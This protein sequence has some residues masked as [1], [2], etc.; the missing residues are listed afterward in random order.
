MVFGRTGK[1]AR[2]VF[3][4]GPGAPVSGFSCASSYWA[5]PNKKALAAAR[6]FLHVG[7]EPLCPFGVGGLVLYDRRIDHGRSGA[8]VTDHQRGLGHHFREYS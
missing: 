8:G 3:P 1:W 6:A 2:L 5:K 4:E 7:E